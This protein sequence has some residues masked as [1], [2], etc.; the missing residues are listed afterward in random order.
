M[1]P[2]KS[3][4]KTQKLGNLAG[5][6]GMI[7]IQSST[8]PVTYNIWQ[9]NTTNIP[10]LSM[11][12]L[13]WAGIVLYLIRAITQKDMLHITSNCIG[14]LTQTALMALIVFK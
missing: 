2:M 10:P 11:V 12:L 7:L 3:K 1:V 6:L 13:V 4:N 5:W 9:G 14:F 8:L